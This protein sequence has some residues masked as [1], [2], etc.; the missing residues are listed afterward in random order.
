MS[1]KTLLNY[2]YV[3]EICIIYLPMTTDPQQSAN[4]TVL[5]C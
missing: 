3:D 1:L 2:N 5:K 4:K